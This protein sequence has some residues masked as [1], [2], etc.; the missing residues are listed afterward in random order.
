MYTSLLV[1]FTLQTE[2]RDAFNQ[3]F[4]QHI[5]PAMVVFK[6][7]PAVERV[8]EFA[9][10]FATAVDDEPAVCSADEGDSETSKTTPDRLL[11]YVFNFML[12]VRD[13]LLN[14]ISLRV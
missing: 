5:K 7:E 14:V 11:S 1:C 9:A 6:R 2:D 10:K 4:L 3:E 12:K 8:L 13:I